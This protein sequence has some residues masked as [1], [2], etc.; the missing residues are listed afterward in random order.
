MTW[1][2]WRDL[3]ADRQRHILFA[4]IR[5]MLFVLIGC[6]ESEP[7]IRSSCM[8][9]FDGEIAAATEEED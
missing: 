3:G 6:V 5:A 4:A 2:N 1:H 7:E 8:R 9:L